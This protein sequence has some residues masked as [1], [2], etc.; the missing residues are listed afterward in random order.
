MKNISTFAV[1]SLALFVL[2]VG[3]SLSG[4]APRQPVPSA[5]P[6]DAVQAREQQTQQY[7]LKQREAARKKN[8][9]HTAH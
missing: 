3:G 9:T 6:V 4:C 1:V 8:R 2:C 5:A 7:I